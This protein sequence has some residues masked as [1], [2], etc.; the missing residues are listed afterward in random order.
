MEII[1]ASDRALDPLALYDLGR[2][3]YAGLGLVTV[4]RTLE[5]WRNSAWYSG[6]TSRVAARLNALE[7]SL[8]KSVVV[9]IWLG[10]LILTGCQSIIPP[11]GDGLKVLVVETFLADITQNI[12]GDRVHV[13]ALVP[14]GLDPHAFE[15][16]PQD[17]AKISS[18]QVL[19]VNG[20]GF[21]SWLEPVLSNAGGQHLVIEASAGLK[22]RAAREGEAIEEPA[23]EAHDAGDPHFW[24]D[25]V[26]AIQYVNNI[27]DGLSQ[28]DPAGAETLCPERGGLYCEIEGPGQL[29]PLPGRTDPAGTPP[30]GDQS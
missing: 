2:R 14:I 13:E 23:G 21:E 30:D 7:K 10:V 6:S 9:F 5:N 1:A 26:S 28:A 4:Y 8:K 11:T 29:D 20:A 19:V 18:S 22:S 27:R 15:P 16:A 24:L 3:E 25:P 17:V 12:A